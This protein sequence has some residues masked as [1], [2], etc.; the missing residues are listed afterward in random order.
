MQKI[1]LKEAW[2]NITLSSKLI[3]NKTECIYNTLICGDKYDIYIDWDTMTIFSDSL[4]NSG[5]HKK[6]SELSKK[7]ENLIDQKTYQSVIL[8]ILDNDNEL[9]FDSIQKWVIN[10]LTDIIIPELHIK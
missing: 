6:I 3:N 4:D 7:S 10:A 2:S 9:I 8:W 1:L 5:R